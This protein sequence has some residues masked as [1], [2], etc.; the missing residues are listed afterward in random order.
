MSYHG[1]LITDCLCPSDIEPMYW[2]TKYSVNTAY[3]DVTV[4]HCYEYLGQYVMS[5]N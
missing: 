1:S 3:N 5:I 2:F 4:Y